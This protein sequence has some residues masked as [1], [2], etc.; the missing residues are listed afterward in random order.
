LRGKGHGARIRKVL[1]ENDLQI[2][3]DEDA[4]F[5]NFE[6][7]DFGDRFGDGGGG[8][9]AGSQGQL[10]GRFPTNLIS[11]A[12][13]TEAEEDTLDNRDDRKVN[14][15]CQTAATATA[16]SSRSSS[17]RG[18]NGRGIG[19]RGR[20]GRNQ[21]TVAATSG[22][23]VESSRCA[24]ASARGSSAGACTIGGV[25]DRDGL[26]N[27]RGRSVFLIVDKEEEFKDLNDDRD[28]DVDDTTEDITGTGNLGDGTSFRN[29]EVSDGDRLDLKDDDG[30]GDSRSGG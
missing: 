11:G 24:T 26:S 3:R 7:E 14:V 28:T 20:V 8:V 1:E 27:R 22:V 21:S 15:V 2:C 10:A 19:R 30:V 23:A 5:G 4:G 29:G 9:G 13:R 16:A 17:I 25:R 6:L 18:K 12:A